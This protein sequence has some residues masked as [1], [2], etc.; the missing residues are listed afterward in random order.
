MEK[1]QKKEEI[2]AMVGVFHNKT[3]GE[4]NYTIFFHITASAGRHS[5]KWLTLNLLLFAD[6]SSQAQLS[7]LM[8]QQNKTCR[9]VHSSGPVTLCSLLV[10]GEAQML[11]KVHHLS[12]NVANHFNSCLAHNPRQLRR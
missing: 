7:P 1:N 8:G 10:H 2:N 9:N 3:I 11:N 5:G 4:C 12:L 6:S